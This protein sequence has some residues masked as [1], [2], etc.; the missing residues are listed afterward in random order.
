MTTAVKQKTAVGGMKIF[1]VVWFGQLVSTLGSG[2][3]GFALGVWI[4]QE[5]GST[6][7]FAINI[8][9]G[10]LP[11]LL[12]SPFAGALVD[13]WDRRK[14]M[15]LSDTGAGLS[16][17]AIWL[18]LS[19]GRLEIWHIYVATA[20]NTAFTAFQWPAYSA[21][22]TLLV[23]K[24]HLGR[25]SG[26]VQIGQAV[27]QLISPVAAG[28]MFVSFGLPGVILIDFITYGVALLTLISVRFPR[29]EVTEA[30]EEGKG[31]IFKEA[32]FGWN[33]LKKLPGF[34][35]LMT[36]FAA[37][38]FLGGMIGPL[39]VPMILDMTTPDIMGVMFTVMGIGM[40]VGTLLMSAWGGP[41]RRI[42]GI[43]LP[44]TAEG[45]FLIIL[46]ASPSLVVFTIAG[47]VIMGMMPITNG[48][49][50]ALWQSKIPADVQGRVF[51]VRRMVAMSLQPVSIL[52]AGPLADNLF[53]PLM[54]ENGPLADSV[55]KI[56]GTGSASGIGLLFICMGLTHMLIG[57]LAY[58]YPRL[59]NIQEEIPDA[60]S[61]ELEGEE[62]TP[63]EL[64][65]EP[66]PG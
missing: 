60:V 9:C 10:T 24:K 61:D 39:L 43:I 65:S 13:R 41:K 44:L 33:Y 42:L 48:S 62:E 23:P 52:V 47:F 58:A 37:G 50:Q 25:A 57:G 45:F 8:L 35:G 59:R 12:V 4:Y 26:M 27:S 31:S 16:T 22:T 6:T 5:T 63:Q 46:G 14:V 11:T 40:L 54:A 49:S 28:F 15:I 1:S 19:T 3:T 18:L 64:A 51:A 34:M 20:F 17:L 38:N 32:A 66:L 7:L 2:L 36:F 29:P 53:K 21:A 30:G 55:G 56:I